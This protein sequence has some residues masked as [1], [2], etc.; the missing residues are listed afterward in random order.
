MPVAGFE[1]HPGVS[2]RNLLVYR[3]PHAIDVTTKPPH[4]IPGETVGPY[5]PIGE[6]A[7]PLRWI[8]DG[9]ARV[10]AGH[11]VNR[12]RIAAGLNP[13][14]QAWL[15]GQGHAAALPTFADRFGVRSGCMITGVDLLRGLAVLLGWDVHEVAGMTSFHDTELR[16]P[17]ASTPRPCSTGTTLV[18][19]HIE[20]PDEAS[21]QADW[22]TKVAAIEHIDKHVVGPVRGKIEDVSRAGGCWCCR[23]I[24]RTLRRASTGT[25]PPRSPSPAPAC[26]PAPAVHRG[27]RRHGHDRRSWARVNGPVPTRVSCAGGSATSVFHNVPLK[28]AEHGRLDE[29]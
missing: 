18:V 26:P 2:Y 24:R 12:R 23:T 25:P 13:A 22:K 27:R 1:Y 29:M 9:S 3:G 15:W 5:L 4:E 11:P 10:F 6:G 8:I 7:G 14:T 17:R 28:R 19:S 21:H 20:A 16:R